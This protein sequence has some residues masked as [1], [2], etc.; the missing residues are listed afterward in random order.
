MKSVPANSSPGSCQG[1]TEGDIVSFTKPWMGNSPNKTL[2]VHPGTGLFAHVM[3]ESNGSPH[4]C[5]Y[6]CGDTSQVY[7][8]VSR[9][10]QI[11][12][13]PA[14]FTYMAHTEYCAKL[15]QAHFAP[16]KQTHENP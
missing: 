3:K 6:P 16:A 13:A 10:D 2:L 9:C 14:H 15:N 5:V 4:I 12:K 7:C 1:I 8:S 11:R